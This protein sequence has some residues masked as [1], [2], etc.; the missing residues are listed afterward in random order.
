MF[1]KEL[2]ALAEMSNKYGSNPEF[3]LA[4]GGN[5]SYKSEDYLF[6]KG[7]GTALSTIT[8][9]G[10]VKLSRKE[11]DAMWDKDYPADE[12]AREAAVLAD[13]MAA[14]VP[15]EERRPSVETLLHELFPQKYILH[16]HP[17]SVNGITCC[18]DGGKVIE[19]LFDTATTVWVP[20][21]KPGYILA[22][23]CRDAFKLKMKMNGGIFPNT[24]YLENH[25]IFVA[26]DTADEAG[27]L[28]VAAYNKIMD[29]AKKANGVPDTAE[30]PCDNARVDAVKA[31]LT[32]LY[33]EG[34]DA[35]VVEFTSNKAA[36]EYDPTT[37]ALSPDHIVYCKACQ[38]ALDS[39]DTLETAFA[40]FEAKNGYQARIVFVK[41]LGMF[42]CGKDEKA[43][44]TALEVFMDAVQG[45]T[46]TKKV[47]GGVKPMTNEMID[48]IMN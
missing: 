3:V 28:L 7:S 43:A 21:C 16:V 37:K 27:A 36:I 6:I 12:D 14:R 29:V 30:L 48:I 34:T 19:E 35:A 32:T 15:G 41:G 11:L 1:E 47:L 5:T 17:T 44:G 13:M 23:N 18:V 42:A 4:G 38:L 2:T 45:T 33:T 31:K 9:D 40:E 25:G 46:F 24:L 22:C 26:A 10:F 20:L 8:P 39:E